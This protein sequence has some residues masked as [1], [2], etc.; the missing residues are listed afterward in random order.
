VQLLRIVT[1]VVLSSSSVA[2]GWMMAAGCSLVTFYCTCVGRGFSESLAKVVVEQKS[3]HSP[4]KIF[5]NYDY[6]RPHQCIPFFHSV[7]HGQ[8]KF[9]CPDN[10][11][12]LAI[13]VRKRP[14]GA[15]SL[16]HFCF[17]VH[18]NEDRHST[19]PRPFQMIGAVSIAGLL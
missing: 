9:S 15:Y 14:L 17:R 16:K 19:R 11:A 18:R 5:N 3:R 8:Q 10:I 7:L 2:V 6:V 13:T 12:L 1:G 4:K